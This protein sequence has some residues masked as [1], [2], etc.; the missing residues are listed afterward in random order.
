MT[1]E[2]GR[3]SALQSNCP[4]WNTRIVSCCIIMSV[5]DGLGSPRVRVPNGIYMPTINLD[6]TAHFPSVIH[7]LDTYWQAV[8]I[9]EYVCSIYP[10]VTGKSHNTN[11]TF[12]SLELSWNFLEPTCGGYTSRISYGSLIW[13]MSFPIVQCNTTHGGYIYRL[14]E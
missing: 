2:R 7:S 10:L 14:R 12:S 6:F 4:N 9:E 1:S 11:P 5:V 3:A 8:K 13:A